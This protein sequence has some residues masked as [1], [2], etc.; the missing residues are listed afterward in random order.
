MVLSEVDVGKCEMP[1]TDIS[2]QNGHEIL[3]VKRCGL[4]VQINSSGPILPF[5]YIFL[6]KHNW[7]HPRS[8]DFS[9]A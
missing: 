9:A 5:S 2:Q 6:Q 4:Q 3:V 1:S 7:Y 8:Q